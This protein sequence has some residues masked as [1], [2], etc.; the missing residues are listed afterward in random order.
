MTSKDMMKSPASMTSTASFHKR[1][2][3]S[4]ML[5]LTWQQN[6]ITW[7]FNVEWIMKNPLFFLALFSLEAVEAMDVTFNQIQ[8]L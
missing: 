2:L 8:G 5:L 1:N 4:M 7:S 6:D 3:L